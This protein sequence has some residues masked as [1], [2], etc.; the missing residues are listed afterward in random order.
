MNIH[1]LLVTDITHTFTIVNGQ[2]QIPHVC[3]T[4]PLEQLV[5]RPV[6]SQRRY[7]RRGAAQAISLCNNF[8]RGRI[9]KINP[10]TPNVFA[11]FNQ[12]LIV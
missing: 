6:P 11:E 5:D 4:I 8:G 12:R 1:A 10:P 2:P 7:D 9:I 3:H